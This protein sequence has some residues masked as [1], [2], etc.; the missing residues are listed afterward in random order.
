MAGK[1]VR[2]TSDEESRAW[3]E[4]VEKVAASAVNLDFD[5]ESD[6]EAGDLEGERRPAG[7]TGK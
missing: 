4:A 7:S 5:E 2:N 3:W 6:R 1:L